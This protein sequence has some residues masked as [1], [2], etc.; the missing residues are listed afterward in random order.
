MLRGGSFWPIVGAFFIAGLLLSLTPC[1]LPMLPIVS[2]IIGIAVSSSANRSKGDGENAVRD[3]FPA[4]T[5]V[6]PSL[7]FGAEDQLFN[8]FANLARVKQA[9][10]DAFASRDP[11]ERWMPSP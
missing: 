4:A 3:A 6:R 1:V 8:R 7:V 10:W 2:S 5:V 9:L 11:T